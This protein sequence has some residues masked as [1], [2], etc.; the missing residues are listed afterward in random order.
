MMPRNAPCPVIVG[1]GQVTHRHPDPASGIEPVDLIADAVAQALADASLTSRELGRVGRIDVVNVLSWPYAHLA[2]ELGKRLGVADKVIVESPAGGEQP[3][4][5]VAA[6]A[7]RVIAGELEMAIICGGEAFRSVGLARR[8]GIE[9]HWAAGGPPRAELRKIVNPLAWDH[10]LKAPVHWYPIFEN[11]FRA[12][13]GQSVAAAQD[14]SARLWSRFSAVAATN[15][16]AWFGTPRTAQEIGTVSESNRMVSFP[17]PKMMNPILD[18][19]QAA[20]VVVMAAGLA[21]R[22]GVPP[23]RMLFPWTSSGARECTDPLLRPNY[24]RSAAMTAAI[25]ASLHGAELAISDID[26]L[27]IYSCFPVVPKMV[28]AEFGID[29]GTALT[30]AGGLTFFGGPGNSYMLHGITAMA[31][32]LRGRAGRT[33]L[34]YG[35][36]EFVTKHHALIIGTEASRAGYRRVGPG[37][38]DPAG[39]PR[40]PELAVEADGPGTIESFTVTGRPE[41]GPLK[42]IVVGRLVD[43]R[44]FVANTDPHDSEAVAALTGDDE[45]IGRPVTS[46]HTN[47]R[48]IVELE[49]TAVR[50]ARTAS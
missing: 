48:N 45:Q 17:Y 6:A 23:A 24:H 25:E 31:R 42:G 20:A 30:V 12:A 15:P 40:A 22:L 34:L 39:V 29:R 32:S 10:G 18:V 26:D 46:R 35:Q 16:G 28:R 4:L 14:E 21:R 13:R 43:G 5:L 33:G 49:P 2:F 3:T 41:R 1:V 47:G 36:G 11:A 8:A 38:P 44:R 7:E 19:D 37:P 50:P 27:E 9:L